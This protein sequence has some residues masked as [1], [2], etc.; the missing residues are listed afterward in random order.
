M[1]Q[2]DFP[3]L[4]GSKAKGLSDAFSDGSRPD[5]DLDSMPGLSREV[6]HDA[7]RTIEDDAGEG[8]GLLGLLNV[9]RMTDPDVNTLALGTDLTSLGLNL[10]S[11]EILYSSFVSPWAESIRKDTLPPIFT[12]PPR[13]TLPPLASRFAS[14]PEETLFYIFYTMP[15]DALQQ[16]AANALYGREWRYHKDL[17]VWV[18]RPGPEASRTTGVERGVFTYFD[19]AQWKKQQKEINLVLES[20]EERRPAPV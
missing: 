7:T 9:I 14:L 5:S 18:H 17:R 1:M 15:L 3:A 8:Y 16:H 10:N 11:P 2:D 6:S 20:F 19:T 4:P 12:A 13:A